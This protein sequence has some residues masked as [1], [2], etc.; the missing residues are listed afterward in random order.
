MDPREAVS[1]SRSREPKGSLFMQCFNPINIEMGRRVPCG[2]C[3][4]CRISRTREWSMRLM[5][6]V[7]EWDSCGFVTLTYREV[8]ENGSLDKIALQR[9][10]KRLREDLKPRK[11]KHFSC[12]EY[13]ERFGRPHY[14]SIIYGIGAHDQEVIEDAWGKGFISIGTVTYDSASYVAGYIQKKLSGNKGREAYGGRMVPFQIQSLGI[15]KKWLE[16]NQGKLLEDGHVSVKGNEYSLPRYYVKKLRE[17][18]GDHALDEVLN[19]KA[20]ERAE[21]HR[22]FLQSHRIEPLSEAELARDQRKQGYETMRA[23]FELRRKGKL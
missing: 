4:A 15:G 23:R 16:D 12:G 19:A 18:H 20:E 5:H 11:I 17:W 22:E 14:H 9:F 10:F 8:P 1:A 2:K 13:G 7:Q 3:M 21:E 6:E